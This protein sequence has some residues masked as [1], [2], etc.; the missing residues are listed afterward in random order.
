MKQLSSSELNSMSKEEMAAMIMQ[1]QQLHEQLQQ[2]QK[3]MEQQQKQMEQQIHTLNEK[4]AIMNARHFGRSTEKLETLPG[5]MNIFNETEVAAA[6]AIAEPAI[7]QVVVRRKKKKGQRKEDLSRLPKRIEN[8]EL[9]KEQLQA[10]FGENGWKR[11]PDEVYSRVEYQPAVKEVVEHHVAVY[12]AKKNDVDTIIKADRPVDLLRNSIATPSLVAAIMNAKYTNA[13]PLYRIAQDFEQSDMILGRSTMANWV[14]RCSERYLSLVYDRLRQHLC[15][16]KI[17]QADETTC[18]VTKDGRPSDA[19]SYMFVYRTS[20][21]CKEK[22]VILYQYGK[23][24]SKSNIQKFLE[25]F[26]G[27]LVSDAFSGYK[28]LDKND[29]NIHSAFCWAHARRDYADALK[30]LKGDAKEL[31]HETVAHKAL[32]QIAAI[33]KAE[34]ALKD[35]TAEERYDRRQR[36]VKPLVEAYF[37]WVHEQDPACILSE[38]TREGLKYSL[39]QEK[40]LK[41]FLEDGNIP[42]DNSATER[43]IRPFTIGRANWHIID[44]IHGAEASATI[45]SLVET[46]KANKLKI[47]EY[48]KHLLTEIPKHMDDTSMD[49]LEDLLPWSEKLPEECHKKI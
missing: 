28:S 20:E 40:Y 23:T 25:G 9:T 24:R 8:H 22:P 2:Q 42:I 47:Y 16:Q 39:N 46:A 5:Q 7:E 33:Y 18:Q 32:V 44:T 29:E 37:A 38:K 10:I 19:K 17:I 13:I 35:L 3:Q 34:E 14:I 4:I 21:H 45:Y 36:E 1:M 31:A 30:A 11:L 15:A 6:E 49:F 26:S 48:L 43:A 41:V 12:A 27:T